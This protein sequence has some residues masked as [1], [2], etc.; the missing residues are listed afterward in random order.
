MLVILATT[1]T[2]FSIMDNC[3][4]RSNPSPITIMTEWATPA[5]RTM[6]TTELDTADNCPLTA[7]QYR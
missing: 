4:L 5:T 7:N 2:A 3:P 6:I 1:T